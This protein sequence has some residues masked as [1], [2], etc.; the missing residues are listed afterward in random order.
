TG[1]GLGRFGPLAHPT[2]V[3]LMIETIKK[4]LNLKTVGIIGPKRGKIKSAAVC[5][6]SCGTILRDVI[7]NNCDFYLTGELKHHHALELQNAGVTTLCT[8]HTNSE[9][10][11]LP[12]IARKLRTA[13]KTLK[14]TTSKK[15]RDPFTWQ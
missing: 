11:I 1:M 12:Q 13:H 14:I 9:R 5:A 3:P 15:D 2:T 7:R 8:S 10:I 6:G 4:A